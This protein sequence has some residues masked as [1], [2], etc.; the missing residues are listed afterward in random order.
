MEVPLLFFQL[1]AFFGIESHV[2]VD[3]VKVVRWKEISDCIVK[4]SQVEVMPWCHIVVTSLAA[5]W[6]SIDLVQG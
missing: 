4:D 2:M 1:I 5:A 6:A 3:T